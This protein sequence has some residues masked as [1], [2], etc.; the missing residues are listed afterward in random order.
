MR[1]FCMRVLEHDDGDITIEGSNNGFT[2][3]ELIGIFDLKKY[4]L[5]KQADEPTSF[6]RTA[7]NRNGVTVDISERE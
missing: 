1:E 2:V 7:V 4:D 3:I 5:L 6:T